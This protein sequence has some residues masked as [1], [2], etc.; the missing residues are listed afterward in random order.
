MVGDLDAGSV[1][2]E[3]NDQRAMAQ[4]NVYMDNHATT[5]VDPRVVEAML[6][7]FTE[8][9]GNAASTTHEFGCRGT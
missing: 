7:Y 6:P 8:T 1:R 9:F 2:R 3:V 5:R 4:R